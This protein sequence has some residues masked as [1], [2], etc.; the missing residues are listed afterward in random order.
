M[1]LKREKI[2]PNTVASR[3]KTFRQLINH[4]IKNPK[5][6][7]SDVAHIFTIFRRYMP[8]EKITDRIINNEKKRYLSPKKVTFY[9]YLFPFVFLWDVYSRASAAL[10]SHCWY[11]RDC[12]GRSSKVGRVNEA[13]RE[14]EAD[15]VHVG[16]FSPNDQGSCA[17]V[18][19]PSVW[20]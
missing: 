16:C 2:S 7:V 11:Q 9:T 14:G 5:I 10:S 8:F 6:S 13:N 3:T 12:D 19:L 17:P 1:K 15:V 4:L 20:Q 18:L